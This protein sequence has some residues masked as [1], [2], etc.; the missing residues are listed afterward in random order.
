MVKDREELLQVAQS[1]ANQMKGHLRRA[2]SGF[3]KAQNV[4]PD[5][6]A[7]VLGITGEEMR[8]I[9]EGDGNITVDALSKLLV[10]TDMAVEIK[11]VRNTPLGAYGKGMPS[12]G[13]FPGPNGIPVDENGCPLPPPPGFMGR[14]P[15]PP[16]G[17]MP[18]RENVHKMEEVPMET[19]G[20][21]RDS[22]GRF[23][24]KTAQRNTATQRQRELRN[25]NPY[26]A[27]ND[28]ELINI[29]RQNIWD[30][31]INIDSATHE[32]LAEFVANKERIMRQRNDGERKEETR[33]EAPESEMKGGGN[34]LNQFLEML[35]NVAR[36]AEH[37]PSLMEAI[38]RFMPRK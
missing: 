15:A 30:S 1:N 29:I 11:P 31:E 6:L 21:A 18:R 38:S 14:M 7:Y 33:R 13:G 32:Q 17:R 5:E 22:H 16:F 20:P 4:S 25:E 28:N 34:A 23:V 12:C 3:L 9:L 35:G 26:M 36:E 37:N 19:T 8:Q 10:A 27:I 2:V 24:K